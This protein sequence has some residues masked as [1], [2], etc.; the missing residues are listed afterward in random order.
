MAN[1]MFVCS[2]CID[3]QSLNTWKVCL[4]IIV[5]IAVMH[6]CRV[7]NTIHCASDITFT[8]TSCCIINNSY[9]YNR[10]PKIGDRLDSK[11]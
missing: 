5:H 1:T 10:F 4:L 7:M 2:M 3:F 9:E 11:L 8:L 6:D